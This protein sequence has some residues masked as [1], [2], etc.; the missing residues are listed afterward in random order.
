VLVIEHGRPATRRSRLLRAMW[1][2]FWIPGNPEVPTSRDLQSRGLEIEMDECGLDVEWH[3]TTDP[4]WIEAF[5]AAPRAA[6]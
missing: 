5:L 2:F 6:P 3:G 1:W 4:D